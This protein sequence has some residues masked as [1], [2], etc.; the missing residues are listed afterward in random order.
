M[1]DLEDKIK[2]MVSELTDLEVENLM[3][4]IGD[5]NC[6]WWTDDRNGKYYDIDCNSMDCDDCRYDFE[7]IRRDEISKEIIK[8]YGLEDMFGKENE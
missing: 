5:G 2:E 7:E 1:M 3:M 8:K 4:A 6:P